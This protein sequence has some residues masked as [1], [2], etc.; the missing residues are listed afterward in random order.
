MKNADLEFEREVKEACGPLPGAD[1]KEEEEEE[2]E[3]MFVE[4]P[5]GREWGG[6]TRGGRLQEP[7]IHGDWQRKGRCSDF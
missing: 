3:E 1:G 4:G 6:P 7:T 5:M 2:M